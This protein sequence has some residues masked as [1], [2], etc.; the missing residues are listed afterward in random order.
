MQKQTSSIPLETQLQAVCQPRLWQAYD[1]L[2]SFLPALKEWNPQL[3]S[4]ELFKER[5]KE[6]LAFTSIELI[7]Y[8][9]AHPEICTTL[10]N[11][12]YD[13]RYSPATFIE[14]WKDKYRVGWVASA[15]EPSINQIRVFSSFAEAAADYV[16]FSWGFPRLA[17]KQVSWSEMEHY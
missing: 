7:E 10:L 14:Q 8:L 13:K 9:Q 1:L 5:A 16:L 12:S 11:D 17:K 15:G 4:A 6:Y 2:V 3:G